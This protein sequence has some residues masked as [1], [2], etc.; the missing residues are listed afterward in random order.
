MYV[1]SPTVEKSQLE[2]C[3]VRPNT[4]VNSD[5]SAIQPLIL[6]FVKS[7]GNT[8]PFVLGKLFRNEAFNSNNSESVLVKARLYRNRR[9]ILVLFN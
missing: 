6:M 7:T 5:N 8:E 9:D 4:L 1:A 2:K 3:I